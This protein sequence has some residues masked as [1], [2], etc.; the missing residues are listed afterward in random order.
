MKAEICPTC[1]CHDEMIDADCSLTPEEFLDRN[2]GVGTWV[3]DRI[4]DLFIV[5]DSSY[6][7]SGKGY[8]LIDR[9]LR[10]RSANIPFNLVN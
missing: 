3:R 4:D 7:G 6:R 10:R 2:F 9:D 1:D 8:I 5:V